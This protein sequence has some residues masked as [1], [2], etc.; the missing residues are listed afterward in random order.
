MALTRLVGDQQRPVTVAELNA[1]IEEIGANI[2]QGLGEVATRA[3][4]GKAS[5]TDN[6][7]GTSVD[8]VAVVPGAYNQAYFKE[9]IATML[10]RL[11]GL[12]LVQRALA[13]LS[14]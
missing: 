7:G 13:R 11:N 5:I 8:T 14:Q 2:E 12:I 3:R 9:T 6:S 4:D 10:N 1:F